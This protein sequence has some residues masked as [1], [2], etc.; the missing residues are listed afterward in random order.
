MAE[1]LELSPEEAEEYWPGMYEMRLM[2][3]LDYLTA[4]DTE[5]P[6]CLIGSIEHQMPQHNYAV[7]LPLAVTARLMRAMHHA[8]VAWKQSAYQE[9]VEKFLA[10]HKK[11]E[12]DE[13]PA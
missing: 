5:E 6:H 13:V 1:H 11:K 3:Q 2:A 4:V 12:E 9:A 8:H 10:E 7:P